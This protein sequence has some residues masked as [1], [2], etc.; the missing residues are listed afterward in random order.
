MEAIIF[1]GWM[2][3]GSGNNDECWGDRAKYQPIDD[4]QIEHIK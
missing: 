3:F 4:Q 1:I 2:S